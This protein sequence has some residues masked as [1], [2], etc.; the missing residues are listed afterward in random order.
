[1]A[2]LLRQATASIIVLKVDVQPIY[3]NMIVDIN[4]T[5]IFI[6]PSNWHVKLQ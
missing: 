1:M 4:T 3:R 2:A 5:S 6:R